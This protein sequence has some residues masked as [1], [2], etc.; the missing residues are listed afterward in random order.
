MEG[1]A[2]IAYIL[3]YV[4]T[5]GIIDEANGEKLQLASCR[6]IK[7]IGGES[8]NVLVTPSDTKIIPFKKNVTTHAC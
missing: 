3:I 5:K 6:I 2:A 4:P 8:Y 1:A 7:Y